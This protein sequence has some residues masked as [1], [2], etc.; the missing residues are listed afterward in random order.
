MPIKSFRGQ[1]ADLEQ[2]K[3]PLSTIDGKTG[4]RI[5]KF[6]TIPAAPG[7]VVQDSMIKIYKVEQDAVDSIV[8]F[9]DNRLLGV[10]VAS[11]DTQLRYYEM[12][13]IIIFDNEVFNQD[14]FVTH[15]DNATGEPCN[16]YIE[17]E[18]IKLDLNEQTVATLKDI[19]NIGAD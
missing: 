7:T 2:R 12:G 14:I 4:Y 6:Q 19:R 18:Q 9:E 16:Y 13:D 11:N 8:N 15:K 10:A 17:L 3:I 1:L 5:T